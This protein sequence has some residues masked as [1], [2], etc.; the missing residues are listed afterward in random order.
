MVT[1]FLHVTAAKV[2]YSY[3]DDEE[4]DIEMSMPKDVSD[5]S[6]RLDEL[7]DEAPVPKADVLKLTPKGSSGGN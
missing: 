1:C 4:D 7:A 6:V 3:S 2:K 5:D